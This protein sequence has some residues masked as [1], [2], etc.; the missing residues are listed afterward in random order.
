ML[1]RHVRVGLAV[2]TLSLVSVSNAQKSSQERELDGVV[3]DTCCW[4]GPKPPTCHSGVDKGKKSSAKPKPG[5][6]KA[7]HNGDCIKSCVRK[8]GAHYVIAP[9]T[10]CPRSTVASPGYILDDRY[11]SEAAKYAGQMVH[12]KGIF[13]DDK[14][15]VQVAAIT[16]ADVPIQIN[17]EPDLVAQSGPTYDIKGWIT[18]SKCGAKGANAGSEACTKKCLDEGGK[19]VVVTD[20][21]QKILLVENPDALKGHEGHHVVVSGRVSGD[22]IHVISASMR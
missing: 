21:D 2:L 15:E 8:S 7:Q 18:D 17:K 13:N 3:T 19:M 1:P 6:A 10:P 16:P 11:A 20:N 22:S 5:A 12:V 4:C 14:H 9:P